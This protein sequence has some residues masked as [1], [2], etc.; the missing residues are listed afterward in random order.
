MQTSTTTRLGKAALDAARW[1][2]AG[3]GRI[4]MPTLVIH[5]GDDPIVPPSASVALAD[6]PATH[7]VV[8]DGFR[9]E[10]FNE[11]GGA[12]ALHVVGS[13]LAAQL[14]DQAPS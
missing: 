3:L 2:T 10:S 8:F 5:G 4:D 13:W 6:L 11:E 1:T 7:R 14:A 12:E 9:H